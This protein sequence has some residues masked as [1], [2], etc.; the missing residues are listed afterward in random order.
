MQKLAHKSC[1]RLIVVNQGIIAGILI[2]PLQNINYKCVN[3]RFVTA[4]AVPPFIMGYYTI[5]I[6]PAATRYN[7]SFLAG[8]L[9]QGTHPLQQVL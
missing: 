5:L 3:T 4:L 7:P 2:A 8:C 6:Y 9:L 1:Y